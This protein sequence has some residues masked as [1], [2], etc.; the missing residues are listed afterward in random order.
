[1][2]KSQRRRAQNRA[3]Q[4]AFRE[5]KEK[6]ARD[7]EAQLSVLS[8]KYNKLEVSHLELNAAYEKLRKTIELLTQDGDDA[9]GEDD[10]G[11]TTRRRSSNSDTLRKLLDI[12]HGEFKGI[13]P[14]KAESP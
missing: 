5:R 2:T 14:V 9:E 4:R 13:A 10:E 6:H 7:L 1:L 11:R 12:L 3:A 8:D